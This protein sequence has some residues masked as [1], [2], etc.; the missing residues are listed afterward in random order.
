MKSIA[1]KILTRTINVHDEVVE[2][3]PSLRAQLLFYFS[4]ACIV[5]LSILEAIH[6]ITLGSWSSEI[7]AVISGLI[8]N[9]VGIIVGK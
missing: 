5:C 9:I 8:G 3:P 1:K 4:T 6:M 7:F 2:V